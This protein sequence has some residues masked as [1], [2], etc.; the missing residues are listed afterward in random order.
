MPARAWPTQGRVP[1]VGD[2]FG[3]SRGYQ[4]NLSIPTTYINK[5]VIFAFNKMS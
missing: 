3:G 2:R 1:S 5:S 4:P